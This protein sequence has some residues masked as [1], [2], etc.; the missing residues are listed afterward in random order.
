MDYKFTQ[1]MNF[2]VRLRELNLGPQ[3]EEALNAIEFLASAHG[4]NSFTGEFHPSPSNGP[5]LFGA[6]YTPGSEFLF[7]VVK[8]S[9]DIIH[10]ND[11]EVEFR[12]LAELETMLREHARVDI[13]NMPY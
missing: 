5:V 7:R 1:Q 10:Q 11:T 6:P 13:Q 12:I 9:L 2:A 4:F 3:F 8:D